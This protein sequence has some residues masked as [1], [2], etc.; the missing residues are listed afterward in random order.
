MRVFAIAI[1]LGVGAITT[2]EVQAAPPPEPGS[3]MFH[4]PFDGGIG[5]LSIGPTHGSSARVTVNV[6]GHMCGS[7]TSM[8]SVSGTSYTIDQDGC[9][10]LVQRNGRTAS[11]KALRCISYLGPSCSFESTAPL[12]QVK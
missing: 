5:D 10:L 2:P 7:I 8:A 11:V 12:R 3:V 1:I 9:Q 4:G 6:V